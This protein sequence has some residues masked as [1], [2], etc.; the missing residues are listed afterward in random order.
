VDEYRGVAGE[1]IVGLLVAELYIYDGRWPV[2]VTCGNAVLGIVGRTSTVDVDG[3]VDGSVDGN[4]SG[5]A[6]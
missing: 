6:L 3:S 4:T 5:Q 2:A 1:H